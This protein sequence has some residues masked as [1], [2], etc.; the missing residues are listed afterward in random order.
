MRIDFNLAG[1][2]YDGRQE[3][4]AEAAA[5][6]IADAALVREKKNRHDK[7]AIRVTGTVHGKLRDFGFVPA[8]HACRIAPMM[9]KNMPVKLEKAFVTGGFDGKF[10]GMHVAV[11]IGF[12][13][14]DP[15]EF[16]SE[17]ALTHG[18]Y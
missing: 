9:D 1:V 3:A 7:N 2:T 16:E 14:V 18:Y 5:Y 11:E 6:G 12:K 10:Y 8:C 15:L 4:L 17:W 13:R